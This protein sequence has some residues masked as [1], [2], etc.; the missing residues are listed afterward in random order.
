MQHAKCSPTSHTLP[1]TVDAVTIAVPTESHLGVALP[2]VEAG[3]PVLVE[4][5]MA[6]SVAEAD[7]LL[8]A[9]RARGVTLAVG[10]TERF[11]PAVA[12]ARAHLGVPAVHRGAPARHVPGAQP[13]HRRRLRPDDSR[14]GRHLVDRRFAGGGDRCGGRAGADAAGRHRQRAPAVRVRVHREPHGEPHQPRSCPQDPLLPDGFLRVDRLRRAGTRSVAPRAAEDRALPASRVASSTWRTRSRSDA[15]WS[16]SWTRSA[17][18]ALPA[19]PATT[20]GAR[21]TR[22]SRSPS[23]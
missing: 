9:A 4:K 5:P 2:L 12:A 16:T 19:S 18:A 17:R 23:R 11:N 1:G 22:H 20:G 15:S 3:V 8:A 21:S 6:R 10:H 13:R 14:S 7:V